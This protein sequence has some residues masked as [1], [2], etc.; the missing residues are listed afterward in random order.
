VRSVRSFYIAVLRV[1]YYLKCSDVAQLGLLFIGSCC[2][3]LLL[4]PR[5]RRELNESVWCTLAE[6]RGRRLTAGGSINAGN[7]FTVRGTVSFT[8]REVYYEFS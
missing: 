7:F 1:K 3:L 6:E 4:I 5:R 2:G 8:R